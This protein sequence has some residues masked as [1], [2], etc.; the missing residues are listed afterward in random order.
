MKG[1]SDSGGKSVVFDLLRAAGAQA[2]NA[3]LTASIAKVFGA[4][5]DDLWLADHGHAGR[6][7]RHRRDRVVLHV[8][9]GAGPRH[10]YGAVLRAPDGARGVLGTDL[11]PGASPTWT[12]PGSR[13]R[14][15]P[16][17]QGLDAHLFGGASNNGTFVDRQQATSFYDQRGGGQGMLDTA[18]SHLKAPKEIHLRPAAGLHRGPG[19]RARGTASCGASATPAAAYGLSKWKV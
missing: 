15:S 5:T 4:G 2:G 1:W 19:E 10:R 6:A 16:T 7:C 3:D 14:G 12:P 11:E 17:R 13:R 18:A 9:G 8:L